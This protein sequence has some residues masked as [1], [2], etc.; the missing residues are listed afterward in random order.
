MKI[1]RKQVKKAGLGNIVLALQ[2]L[3]QLIAKT[4]LR[5]RGAFGDLYKAT[6]G[7]LFGVCLRILKDRGQS[8][9]ALQEVFVKIWLNAENY[10]SGQYSP[11]SWLITIAR[12]HAIDRWRA[13]RTLAEGLDAAEQI[14]DTAANPE[15]SA[16]QT[17]VARQIDRCLAELES[18]RARAVQAAYVEGFSYKELAER[19][20]VPLNTMRTWLRRSLIQ[21]RE[22]LQR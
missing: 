11:M 4:A 1:A 21:L 13:K 5:D 8:E 12:N 10:R 7:K 3:D 22:C 17:S 9:D 20:G 6:S 15:Q 14:E 16:I 2:T 18:D 19:H